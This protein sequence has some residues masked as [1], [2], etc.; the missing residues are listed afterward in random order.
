MKLAVKQENGGEPHAAE[1]RPG[2]LEIVRFSW[3]L[4]PLSPEASEEER[5]KWATRQKDETLG[6]TSYSSVY[7]FLYIQDY[8]VRHEILIPLL[9]LEQSLLIARNDDDALDLAEQE[10]ARQQVEAYFRS[11]NPI[12]IDGVAVGAVVERCDFFGLDFKDFALQAPRKSVP[13]VSARVGI[14]LSYP[15][16]GPPGTVK[17]TWNRFNSC[18]WTVNTVVF[19]Y[20]AMSKTTLT[21]LGKNNVFEWANPGRPAAPSIRQVP[22]LPPPPRTMSL[23]VLSIFC[24]VSCPAVV[25]VM[26]IRGAARRTRLLAGGAILVVAGIAWPYLRWNVADPFAPNPALSEEQAK[27]IFATLQQNIYRALDFRRESEIYDALAKS[28]HGDLLEGVY[29][30]MRRSLEMQ[31]QGGAVARVRK[32]SLLEGRQG[33]LAAPGNRRTRDLP[34]FSYL[35]RWN[36]S[37]TVEHWGHIHERTNQYQASFTIEPVDNAW[38][39]TNIQILDER[40]LQF[41]TRLR[42]L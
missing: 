30:Q 26:T 33:P 2:D 40:R 31:E 32:V 35:C 27:T 15:C 5:E 25:L 29:R 10:A 1:L 12:E 39:V 4:P 19:A 17:L 16:G 37:G 18:V 11:G 14:I 34:G 6:I 38:K 20:D 36:V 8:E 42:G 41:E 21:R 24:L 9:T 22:A 23:P 13:M 7:S 3:D 28:I